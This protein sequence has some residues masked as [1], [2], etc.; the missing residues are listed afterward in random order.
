MP[1]EVGWLLVGH[2][3]TEA[4]AVDEFL[5]TARQVAQAVPV[6]AVEPCFLEFARPTI[7]DGLRA[8]ASRGV[9]RITVVPVMLFSAAHVQH[10]IPAA[11]AAASREFPKIAVSQCEHFGCHEAILALS[12][13]RY[14]EA[15]V[16]RG[17]VDSARTAAGVGRAGKS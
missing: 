5:Q 8:L 4:R 14:E 3:S 12:A 9:R 10:D 2:G 1:A 15:I 13:L 16:G 17:P 11:V 6:V 7:A